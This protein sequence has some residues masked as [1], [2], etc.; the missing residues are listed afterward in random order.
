MESVGLDLTR[1]SS[2]WNVIVPVVYFVFWNS[3]SYLNYAEDVKKYILRSILFK[4]YAS[5]TTG[6]LKQMRD[7][8]NQNDY[9]LSVQSIDLIPGLHLTNNMV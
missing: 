5:G 1:F 3:E 9:I 4:Y 2:S 6:K 8:I 7:N